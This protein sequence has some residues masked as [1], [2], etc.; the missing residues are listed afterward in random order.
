MSCNN[1]QLK[2]KT[3][4]LKNN[5]STKTSGNIKT[6]RQITSSVTLAESKQSTLATLNMKEINLAETSTDRIEEATNLI[7]AASLPKEIDTTAEPVQTSSSTVQIFMTK[8]SAKELLPEELSSAKPSSSDITPLIG[9]SSTANFQSIKD[10][11]YL[12]LHTNNSTFASTVVAETVSMSPTSSIAASATTFVPVSRATMPYTTSDTISPSTSTSTTSTT[13]TITS[14]TSTPLSTTTTTTVESTSTTTII[15]TTDTITTNTT[16][17]SPSTEAYT[18]PTTKAAL[19]CY[20]YF[21]IYF[22]KNKYIQCFLQDITKLPNIVS[23][24]CNDQF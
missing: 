10:D 12:E 7:N 6:N 19:V 18:T 20:N 4:D 11:S 5:S 17:T 8:S 15:S 24:R 23:K 22:I 14:T 3:T 1:V 2:K 9:I 16:P 21:I 13:T